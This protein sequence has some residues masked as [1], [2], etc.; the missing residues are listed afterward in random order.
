MLNMITENRSH[1]LLVL[2]F[3]AFA[4]SAMYFA[5][6]SSSASSGESFET[7]F[8]N[9]YSDDDRLE[10]SRFVAPFEHGNHG[11][12]REWRKENITRQLDWQIDENKVEVMWE[13][14]QFPESEVREKDLENAWQLYSETF[15]AADEK[16]WFNWSNAEADG[17]YDWEID[18]LHYIND[19]YVQNNENLNPGKPETLLYIDHPSE[20]RILAGVMYIADGITDKGPQAA[21][22]LTVWHY[23]QGDREECK[24]DGVIPKRAEPDE[25]GR[26]CSDGVMSLRG[27]EMLHVWFLDH[28][29]GPFTSRMGISSSKV[30]QPS[31]MDKSEFK[32]YARDSYLN[33]TRGEIMD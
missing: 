25:F 4:V 7:V 14:T 1:A 27:P 6:N 23:H 5:D 2:L 26:I 28:P 11:A 8:A 31:K 22:P 19:D 18:R 17:Y 13:I 33:T 24:K 32:E 9:E 12:E 21:G 20:G 29:E 15:D 16:D 30:E 3:L 10:S